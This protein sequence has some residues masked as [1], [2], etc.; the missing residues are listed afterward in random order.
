MSKLALVCFLFLIISSKSKAQNIAPQFTET[1]ATITSIETNQSGRRTSVMAKVDYV[2]QTGDSLSSQ[3]QLLGLPILGSF[4][5]EGDIITILYD[6]SNPYL[7]KSKNTSFLESYGL[8]LFIALGLFFTGYKF[9]KRKKD[10]YV[11]CL[12]KS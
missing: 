5:K 4:K 12:L 10:S 7:I 2:T 1:Q 3:V 9:L 8:Y 11:S 6:E